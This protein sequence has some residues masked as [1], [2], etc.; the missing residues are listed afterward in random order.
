MFKMLNRDKVELI[1]MKKRDLSIEL[2]NRLSVYDKLKSL[3]FV[4]GNEHKIVLDM[5]LI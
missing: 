5:E 3:D 4:A 2:F 1:D